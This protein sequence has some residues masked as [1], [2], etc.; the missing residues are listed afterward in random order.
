MSALGVVVAVKVKLSVPCAEHKI[1][2]ETYALWSVG[3]GDT[4]TIDVLVTPLTVTV[5]VLEL[6]SA[7]ASVMVV[8]TLVRRSVGIVPVDVSNSV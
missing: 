8:L 6:Q 1:P 7:A 2:A 3:S 4:H 5:C